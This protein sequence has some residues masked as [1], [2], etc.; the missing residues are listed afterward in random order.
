MF[1]KTEQKGTKS[2]PTTIF[3]FYYKFDI[4]TPANKNVLI[5]G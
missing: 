1:H 5:T 2:M 4:V 3:N